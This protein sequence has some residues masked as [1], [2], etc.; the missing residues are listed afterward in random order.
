MPF[1]SGSTSLAG[2]PPRSLADDLRDDHGDGSKDDDGDELTMHRIRNDQR[3]EKLRGAGLVQHGTKGVAAGKYVEQLCD[4]G[5]GELG[6]S[7]RTSARIKC[8]RQGRNF[9]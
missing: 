4:P 3:R 2:I 5:A 1:T 6:R 9:P 8:L 7:G